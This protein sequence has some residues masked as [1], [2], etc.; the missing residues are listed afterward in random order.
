MEYM[1]LPKLLGLAERAWAK[2]PDWATETDTTKSKLLYHEAWNQFVNVLGK[3]ELPRLDNYHNGFNYRIPNAGAVSL[4]GQVFANVQLPGFTIRYTT[5]GEIPTINSAIY[6]SPITVK[7]LIKLA[8]FSS[9]RR[10]GKT[11][12]V[13]NN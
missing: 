1:L 5:N 8:V 2:D 4:N 10:A 9:D 6:Q 11:V 7:G 3:R 12:S 13:Q